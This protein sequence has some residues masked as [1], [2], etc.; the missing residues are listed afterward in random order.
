MHSASA[1]L[2]IDGR[3]A[4][5]IRLPGWKPDVSRSRSRKPA[6]VPVMSLPAS[7]SLVIVSN[8][9]LSRSSMCANSLETR[10]CERLKTIDSARVDELDRLA[11]PVEAEAGDVVARA[12]QPA[13]RRH[14][15]DDARVVRGVRGRGHERRELVHALLPAGRVERRGAVELVDDRDRVDRLALRVEREDRLVDVTV[16]LAVEVGRAQVGGLGDRPD[17]QGREHHRPEHGFLRVEV[18]RRDR[19]GRECLGDGGHLA[20]S[21]PGFTPGRKGVERCAPVWKGPLHAGSIER[22]FVFR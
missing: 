20:R 19:G 3:A 9:S 17:R 11:R 18:L 2:P 13:Q 12:D 8:E 4:T 15:A 10:D 5:M 16:A 7:Y 21:R 6:G 22:V 14:L 1:D